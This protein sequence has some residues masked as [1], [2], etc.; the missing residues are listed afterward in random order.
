VPT[1]APAG[2]C[3][4][5]DALMNLVRFGPKI[6]QV[7]EFLVLLFHAERS[8]MYGKQSDQ[9]SQSQAMEGVWSKKENRWIR[10]ACGV[11]LTSWKV[12]NKKLAEG[13]FVRR[14]P[15]TH[16][17]GGD[18]ATEY[19]IDWYAV[20]ERI[21]QSVSDPRPLFEGQK[22]LDGVVATRP[23]PKNVFQSPVVATRPGGGRHATRGWSPHGHPPPPHGWSPRDHTVSESEVTS[24]EVTVSESA[25]SAVE[26]PDTV[27]AL[28]EM[29]FSPTNSL[30][31]KFTSL[32][33][34]FQLPVASVCRFLQDKV[35]KKRSDEYPIT[36][37]GAL[38][39]FAVKDL[40]GWAKQHPREIEIDYKLQQ[41][42]PMKAGSLV[43]MAPSEPE[44]RQQQQLLED[45]SAVAERKAMR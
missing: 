40:L 29:K 26:I 41:Q 19:E 25:S 22:V 8:T 43:T 18:A 21:D 33:A 37:A 27:E 14:I 16:R 30:K 13:G 44:P 1:T 9:A 10:G 36:S 31:G 7:N 23:P 32:A 15:R 38:Y 45:I 35:S 42:Q 17:S 20:K 34:Q 11:G 6:W 3:S 39:D 24:E 5:H 12:A 28:L 2:Y 4:N